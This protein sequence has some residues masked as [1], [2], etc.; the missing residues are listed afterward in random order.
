M[1]KATY[2]EETFSFRFTQLSEAEVERL[3]LALPLAIVAARRRKDNER[4]FVATFDL[5]GGMDF[6]PLYGF[7][8]AVSPD[9]KDYSV[10]ISLRTDSDHDGLSLPRYVLEIVRRIDVGVDFSFV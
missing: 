8:E 5:V 10:W 4:R 9:P 1:V 2:H 3:R 7:I 6:E